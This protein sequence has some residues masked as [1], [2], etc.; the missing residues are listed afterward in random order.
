MWPAWQS[1]SKNRSFVDALVLEGG[2]S[3]GLK[4]NTWASLNYDY[5]LKR[6]PDIL[7]NSSKNTPFI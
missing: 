6:I 5:S 1:P 3:V 4:L 2:A 7:K